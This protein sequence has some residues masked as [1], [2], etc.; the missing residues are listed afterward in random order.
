MRSQSER[1]YELRLEPR[2]PDYQFGPLFI[3]PPLSGRYFDTKVEFQA[4]VAAE[5]REK[6]RWESRRLYK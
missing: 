6:E 5:C 3:R 2:A 4:D 1:D